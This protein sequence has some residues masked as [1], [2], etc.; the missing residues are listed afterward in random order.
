MDWSNERYVRVY[1]RDTPE[2]LILPWQAKALWPLLVRKFDRSGVIATKL[3]ARGVAVLVGLPLDVVEPGLDALLEDGCLQKHDLGY[4][5]PNFIEAQETPQ[6]DANRKRESRERR[7]A[8]NKHDAPN[9]VTQTTEC[10]AVSREVTSCHTVSQVVTPIP[11]Q[12]RPDPE[13]ESSRAI[14]PTAVPGTVPSTTHAQSFA[15]A[16]LGR[17]RERGALAEA[18]WQRLS[19]LRLKHAAKLGVAVP[20]PFAPVTPANQPRGFRE[21]LDR[22]REE[23]ENARTV[24]DHVLRVLDK[25]ATNERSVEWLAEKAFLAGPWEKAR[26][27]V[28][29]K[30]KAP[31]PKLDPPSVPVEELAGSADL[32]AAWDL[33]GITKELT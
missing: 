14:P 12:T 33:L 18:T 1:T 19:E 24:C 21:L 7:R 27:T 20:F 29:A 9:D 6:S 4:L 8:Q 30:R 2:W 28:L 17:A 11:D 22:I 5:A 16:D 32:A 25:Q 23:G 13:R 26:N 31:A 15:A 3:G 10:H